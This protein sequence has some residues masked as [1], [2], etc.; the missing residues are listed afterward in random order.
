MVLPIVVL[1]A[2]PIFLGIS[3]VMP[4][5]LRGSKLIETMDDAFEAAKNMSNYLS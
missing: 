5:K 3:Y 4:F 2:I 1:V